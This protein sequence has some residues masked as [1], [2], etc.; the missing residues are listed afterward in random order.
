MTTSQIPADSIDALIARQLPDWFKH[1]SIEHLTLLRAA[2][3]RQ[4]RAQDQLNARLQ[5]IVPLDD[6]AESLLKSALAAHSNSQIDPRLAK[7]KLVTLRPNPP[8]SAALSPF[9]ARI[10]STQSLL[11]AALHNFHVNETEPGWFAPG[12]QLLNAGGKR[13]P[14]SAEVFVSLCRSLDIG[15]HYQSHLRSQLEAENKP[16]FLVD[17]IMEEALSANLELAATVARIKGEID[18]QTYQRINRVVGT[19]P[20]MPAAST[21]LKCHTLRLLGKKVVGALVIEV[22]QNA[23]LLGVIAW[24]PEDRYAPVGWHTSWEL[25]YMTLGMRMRDEAYRRFFQRFVAERDRVSFYTAL[26]ALLSHGSTVLPLE[27]DGRCFAIEGEVFAALRKD[28]LDKMLDDARVLAVSTEDEDIAD[29]HARLQGYLDLGLSVAG[30][31]ALFVPVLGQAMLGLTVVQ[32]AGEVYEGYQDWQLGDRNAA[33]SHVFNVAET[34]ALGAVTAVGVAALG[35]L[36]Q[37]VARVDALVPIS[38]ADGQLRLCDPGLSG[39]QLDDIDLTVGQAVHE[40]GRSLRR[41][42]DAVY[43]VSEGDDGAWR[44]HHPSRPGAY[45]PALE[46]NG[47]GGWVH[48]FE[49]PQHWQDAAYMVRRLATRTA[50][51]SDEAAAVALQAT[52]YGADQLRRLLLENA[53]PPARLLDAIERWQLHNEF[54]ALRGQAFEDVFNERQVNPQ[55]ADQVLMRDFPSLSHRCAREIV[56]QANSI[57]LESLNDAGRLPLTLAERARWAVRDSRIDRACAGLRQSAAANA[58]TEKLVQG[59]LSDAFTDRAAAARMIGLVQVGQGIRPPVRLFDGRLGY[60]LSGHLS[61]TRQALRRTLNHVFPLMTSE[62]LESYL[63]DLAQ[64][65]VEPWNHVSQL[66]QGKASLKQALQAWR[67]EPGLTILRRLRRIKVARRIMTSWRRMSSGEVAGDYHLT[68]VGD[69]V[70]ELPALPD[71]VAFDHITHLTLRNMQ[72]TAVEAGFFGRF[73]KVRNLDLR[74]NRLARLPAGIEQL[75]ELRNLRLGGNQIVL[76]SAD[77][78]RLSQ[79]TGLRWLEMNGNPVGLLP[80]LA[81]FPLLRRLSLRNTGMGALPN[82]LARHGNL[83]LLDMRDNQIQTLP[84]ALS[85]LPLRLLQGLE[86]HENPISDDTLQR[87]QLARAAAGAPERLSLVHT[88]PGSSAATPWLTGYTSTQRELRLGCWNRLHQ[89]AGASDL[90]RFISDLRDTHEYHTQ[91]RDLRAR[92]WQVLEACEQH[93]EVRAHLFEQAS[94]PRSCGDELLLTL[95]ELEVGALVA[96][97]GTAI[98]GLQSERALVLL[99]RSLSRLDKVNAIAARH[100]AEY[101]SNDPVEVY[102]TYRVRLADS[103]DLPAQPSHLLYEEF[104]GVDREDLNSARSEV[105][106]EETPQALAQSLADRTFWQTYL[107]EH[108]AARFSFVDEP[109]QQ[110]LDALFE[111]SKTLSDDNYLAQTEQIR[112]EREIAQRQLLLELTGEVI[113]RQGL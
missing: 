70:G 6:F 56:E 69:R 73:S 76:S 57:E 31:A 93:A 108:E 33:L 38:L 59:G 44:I 46:H 58:D 75:A 37:R 96:K 34:V 29:R 48:E 97:A 43:E 49:Q 20:S 80:P 109:F 101:L 21:V 15:R 94:R 40:N 86:L 77:N 61:G 83:E 39:Y 13:L 8:I 107:N 16:G 66:L 60:P 105:L 28:Q 27:L 90:F 87:L 111:Q 25:L 104:S 81:S 95:S 78:L 41:L 54:P 84:E 47:V 50:A 88:S 79:L 113:Q 91:P 10:E 11:S 23:R 2:S 85:A 67:A 55:A 112:A 51:V 18:E 30:L 106:Q 4:Q 62:Q 89:E 102:L 45:V 98:D 35:K 68:I 52:G 19:S 92:V 17:A 65:G 103:L 32:L 36:A 1:A 26:N 72:L 64:R 24:L 7:V 74:D 9:S 14:L 42:H 22:R 12:S 110:R 82:D 100:I 63:Q 99:G 53:P 5:A 71:N 3:L